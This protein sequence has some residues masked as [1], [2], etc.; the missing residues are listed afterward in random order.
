MKARVLE[1]IKVMA[2]T[3]I[4][5]P[6]EAATESFIQAG[7]FDTEQEALNLQKYL[8]TKFART[9]LA[10]KKATQDNTREKWQYVPR[11]DFTAASDIDWSKSIR[12]IDR[13]LYAKYGLSEREVAFI[14]AALADLDEPPK[15]K[16]EREMERSIAAKI[17][18]HEAALAKIR[19]T[20]FYRLM[21]DMMRLAQFS[22]TDAQ[23]EK[24]CVEADKN[25]LDWAVTVA[26]IDA[27]LYRKYGFSAAMIEFVERRYSYD[28]GAGLEPR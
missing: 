15:A 3:Q 10:A 11:Q 28:D 6:L 4:S 17:L 21:A 23:A 27:Q 19:R 5:Y 20:K 9:L 24:F 12:E 13:Q 14:E 7:A 26:E 2:G 25:D 22:D 8:K 16:A 1:P 18:G